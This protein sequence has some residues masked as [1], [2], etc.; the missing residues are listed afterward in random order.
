MNEYFQ[1]GKA[2]SDLNQLLKKKIPNSNEELL[3]C[4]KVLLSNPRGTFWGQSAIFFYLCQREEYS[5][6]HLNVCKMKQKIP[7]HQTSRKLFLSMERFQ[8]FQ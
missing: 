8:I 2:L 5:V 7:T 6:S 3:Q 1:K 4:L